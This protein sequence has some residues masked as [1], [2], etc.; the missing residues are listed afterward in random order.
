MDEAVVEPAPGP[1]TITID[2][3]WAIGGAAATALVILV[4]IAALIF[5]GGD[6]HEHPGFG[7]GGSDFG[8]T[9][10]QTGGMPAPPS[11]AIPQMPSGRD[12]I[13]ADRSDPR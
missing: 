5:S 11:G 2:R 13:D 4:L 12:S 1:R 9:R 3:R 10:G 7:P 6:S 8:A